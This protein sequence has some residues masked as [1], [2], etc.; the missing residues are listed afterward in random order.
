MELL[1]L[2]IDI[3]RSYLERELKLNGHKFN[4]YIIKLSQTLDEYIVKYEKKKGRD[5]N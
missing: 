1:R 4:E 3:L 2:K 5:E